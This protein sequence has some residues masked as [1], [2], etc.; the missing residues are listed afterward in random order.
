MSEEVVA[1]S[2]E[3]FNSGLFCAE[4]VLLAIAE[5]RGVDCK[6]I[7]R[8]ATGFCSGIARSGGLCG[9]LSGAILALGL[10]A[11]RDTADQP[12]GPT[13]DLVREVL[14]GFESRFGGTSCIELTGCDLA[15]DEGQ[16]RFLEAKQHEACTEYVGEATR[17]VLATI[18]NRQDAPSSV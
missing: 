4:S 13:Y 14:G 16:R 5:G 17:L 12:I 3:L 18:G 6:L 9:A 8:I 2:V 7:P 1:R 11:G 15:T 10:V